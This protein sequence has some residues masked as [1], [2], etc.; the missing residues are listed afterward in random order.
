MSKRR[1]S[2][3]ANQLGF[4]FDVPVARRQAA[5]LAGLD[6]RV[7]AAV[8]MALKDDPRSRD[9]I[10]GAVSALL[11]EP[12][13]KLMLDAYASEAR[14]GHAISVARFMALIVV[15]N[16]HDLFDAL[17]R[18]TGAALLVGDEIMTARAGHLRSQI[19]KIKV[20]LARI[21]GQHVTI[22]R[23]S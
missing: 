1:P 17:V 5:G 16:R 22:G 21:E 3:D 23:A 12:V 19:A 4:T 7:S 20:E 2:L 6:R 15:T 18:E 10:A 8:S 13:S 14:E 11:D 9:E